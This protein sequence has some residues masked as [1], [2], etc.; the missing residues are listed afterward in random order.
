[1]RMQIPK[2]GRNHPGRGQCMHLDRASE[3]SDNTLVAISNHVCMINTSDVH[4]WRTI[5]SQRQPQLFVIPKV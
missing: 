2:R 4:V 3:S 1:M 5:A